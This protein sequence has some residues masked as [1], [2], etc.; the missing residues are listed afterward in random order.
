MRLRDFYI[1]ILLALSVTAVVLVWG[2]TV[3]YASS[4]TGNQFVSATVEDGSGLVSWFKGSVN[5]PSGWQRLSYT[6]YSYLTLKINGRIYSNNTQHPTHINNYGVPADTVSIDYSLGDNAN[7]LKIRDTIFTTWKFG[8]F[9]I[10]QEIYPVAFKASGQ[11]ISLVKI[12]NHANLPISAQEEFLLD[13]ENNTN[14]GAT[15]MTRWAYTKNWTQ[16]PNSN[17]ANQSVPPFYCAFENPIPPGSGGT[18]VVSIGYTNDSLAPFPLGLTTPTQL[19]IGDW[20]ILSLCTWGAPSPLS[21]SP[22]YPIYQD[23]AILFQWRQSGVGTPGSGDSIQEIGRMSYGTE[24]FQK[25]YGNMFGLL[26]YPDSIS[27]AQA[28]AGTPLNVLAVFCDAQNSSISN[29][30]AQLV[31]GDSLYITKPTA[32]PPRDSAQS[33]L[34]SPSTLNPNQNGD[35]DVGIAQWTITAH[36]TLQCS[37]SFASSIELNLTGVGLPQPPFITQPD[38]TITIGCC[39][40]DTVAPIADRMHGTGV[41]DSN[42]T[43]H[44]SSA[45]D[46]GLKDIGW[47]FLPAASGSNL[48]VTQNPP[49]PITNCPKTVYTVTIQQLDSTKGGCIDFY[50]TDCAQNVSYREVCFKAHGVSQIPDVTPPQFQ[51]V[52]RGGWPYRT[53]S[54]RGDSSQLCY[55]QSDDY[56]I[57]DVATND[58]GL[59]S[60]TV[61]NSTNMVLVPPTP[62]IK[63]GDL[64]ASFSVHVTD[65]MQPGRIVF[66]AIDSAGNIAYDSITYCPF[67]DTVAPLVRVG[68]LTKGLWPVFATDN[69]AWDRGIDSIFVTNLINAHDSLLPSMP[70]GCVDSIKFFIVINDTFLA[71]SYCLQARDCAGNVNRLF[72]SGTSS[73]HDSYCPT[74]TAAPPLSTNPDSIVV[75]VTDNHL[76]GNGDTINYDAGIDS[77]WFS[78]VHNMTLYVL[79]DPNSPYSPPFPSF[80]Y[81]N[82]GGHPAYGKLRTFYIA[83]TD[84]STVDTESACVT[85]NAIDG[86]GNY[87][88]SP[89]VWCYPLNQDTLPPMI[90]GRGVDHQT[91]TADISDNRL[92]DRGI[93]SIQFLNV[94][95]FQTPY[96]WLGK[97]AKDTVLTLKVITPGKSAV[98]TLRS[99]D[100]IFHT[101]DATNSRH[102]AMASVAQYVQDLHMRAAHIITTSGAFDVPVYL[103]NT[104]S[105]QLG[106][107]NLSQYSFSFHLVGSNLITFTGPVTANTLSSGW[108]V[109]PVSPMPGYYTITGIA[110][111]GVTMPDIVPPDT[112]LYLRFNG[113]SS[114]SPGETTIVIDGTPG[115]E[116]SYNGGTDTTLI[117]ESSTM[118]QLAPYGHL[119]GGTIVI[120]GTCSPIVTTGTAP[121]AISLAP[122]APNP[123]SSSTIVD[124]TIPAEAMVTL[125]LYNVIG[126]RMVT[127]VSEVQKQGEYQLPLNTSS[128][129]A[130]TYFLRLE[131]HGIVCS[132]RIIVTK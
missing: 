85:I 27:C 49:K 118:V 116:V 20:T 43:V 17:G 79:G 71:A 40:I 81:P 26:F 11:I 64:V 131:S 62:P 76:D 14:D 25:L 109:T 106:Q 34:T 100:K 35:L 103:D 12:V 104:D 13:V 46:L 31:V 60:L 3:T 44:D 53:N 132:E 91:V 52:D 122:T 7:S 8:S 80:K 37:G 21:S 10:V 82:N 33:Q 121:T 61:V 110:P 58:R 67:P 18:G 47:A 32:N 57:S 101:G 105:V 28:E 68:P 126:E 125:E 72:C 83:V 2:V 70:F 5:N 93:D 124:Y 77:V 42:F 36:K 66:E 86:A 84:T 23:N 102:E 130:G 128:L 6:K 54:T 19:T 50:F 48:V 55:A 117:G 65:T 24:E 9:D 123:A 90:N 88:C 30:T 69:K 111:I 99:T 15:I 56:I 112:L 16:Y 29:T 74:I 51:L 95:N 115:E 94:V 92:N 87:A 38:F 96:L 39:S 78:G 4:T 129:P 108:T 120:K 63:V 59:R 97:G 22:V 89:L 73:L 75:T 119:E 98:G 113:A 41:F 107:K 1:Q 45:T 127:I 114:S